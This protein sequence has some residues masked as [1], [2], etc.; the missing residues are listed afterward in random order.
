MSDLQIPLAN[1]ANSAHFTGTLC[2]TT[3]FVPQMASLPLAEEVA[4]PADLPALMRRVASL[5]C[6]IFFDSAR[7][8]QR[9]GRYSFL[10]AAPFETISGDGDSSA[11]QRLGQRCS[12]H[13]PFADLAARLHTYSCPTIDGLPPFQGGLAGLFTY[14]MCHRIERLPQTRHREF[15]VPEF[16]AGFYDWVIALDH[17]TRRTW[18]ISTGLPMAGR[19]RERHAAKRLA[20]ARRLIDSADQ[21][22]ARGR[23]EHT[24]TPVRPAEVVE[25]FPLQGLASGVTT[26][27][28]RREFCAAV[29]RTIDYIHAGDVYQVNLAQRLL[30]PQLEPAIDLFLRLREQNAAP[31]AGYFAFDNWA[32]VS[33]SPERFLCVRDRDVETRP[34]K[35]TRPRFKMPLAD[36]HSRHELELSE[37]DRAENIMIVDLL[38][39][40]LGRVCEYGSVRVAD[41]L[42]I[43]SFEFVHHL[44]TAVHGRLRPGLGPLD[45]LRAAFP[46]GS[47]TGAPKIRAMQVI[48][49]LEPT[50][51]GAYCGSLAYIGFDGSMD[52]SILIRTFTCGRGWLQFPVGGGIVADSDPDRE[53]EET[54]HKAEGLLRALPASVERTACVV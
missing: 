53:F 32:V 4:W 49:E 30:C 48:A 12:R 27:F 2:M 19:A 15:D 37:K 21:P 26:N 43:E 10:T 24:T 3:A 41:P 20:A 7:T 28:S 42:H 6:P 31:F 35:G 50:A 29:R 44:V 38:R 36:M 22:T 45:V 18:V 25:Q 5:P 11:N 51:R 39:N 34:I 52:S 46:G 8:D 54:L 13:D 47:V 1:S 33:A 9:L 23:S 17:A 14:D 16:F 40:D